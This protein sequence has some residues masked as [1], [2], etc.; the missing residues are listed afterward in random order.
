MTH[1]NPLSGFIGPLQTNGNTDAL[2]REILPY[3]HRWEEPLHQSLPPTVEEQYLLGY[4]GPH[5]MGQGRN[6]EA[7]QFLPEQW[8][9]Q[10]QL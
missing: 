7:C 5:R 4:Q 1:N 9:W 6:W 3:L 8:W 2:R 10:V